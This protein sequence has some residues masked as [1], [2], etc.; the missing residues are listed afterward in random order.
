ML[1]NSNAWKC[2][3]QCKI[4]YWSSIYSFIT[5]AN[6]NVAKVNILLHDSDYSIIDIGPIR[7]NNWKRNYFEILNLIWFFWIF[8]KCKMQSK[9]STWNMYQ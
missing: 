5:I 9:R 8:V 2:D 4:L 1:T 7:D 3:W 6:R